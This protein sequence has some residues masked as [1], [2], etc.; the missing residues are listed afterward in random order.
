MNT[1]PPQPPFYHSERFRWCLMHTLKS[2]SIYS[3]RTNQNSV[4]H[5]IQKKYTGTTLYPLSYIFF[6][7]TF[8]SQ[9][10]NLSKSVFSDTFS[11]LFN[12]YIAFHC[13]N[14]PSTIFHLWNI[15]TVSSSL[16]LQTK[17]QTIKQ[18]VYTLSKNQLL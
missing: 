3:H 6:S 11:L 2:I 9:S 18:E 17:L 15:D 5:Q 13:I 4:I 10:D 12:G 7:L 16:L 1:E 14:V 8:L